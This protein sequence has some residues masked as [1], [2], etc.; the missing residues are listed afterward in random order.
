MSGATLQQNHDQ[1][2]AIPP[3][4]EDRARSIRTMADQ[5]VRTETGRLL[6]APSVSNHEAM[7]YNACLLNDVAWWTCGV[8]ALYRTLLTM[9]YTTLAEA[10]EDA[11]VFREIASA[12]LADTEQH[13]I[14]PFNLGLYFER[15]RNVAP[16]TEHLPIPLLISQMEP[17]CFQAIL[18][19]AKAAVQD[20][21]PHLEAASV[22][23]GMLAGHSDDV[24]KLRAEMT[25]LVA[26]LEKAKRASE[27]LAEAAS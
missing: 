3:W 14:K 4:P 22:P 13:L 2:G 16:R 26:K 23:G 11:E 9:G 18:R 6:V 7:L 20:S 19:D 25:A 27:A 5:R 8:V 10:T 17:V 1:F 21:V 15:F 24:K 12:R